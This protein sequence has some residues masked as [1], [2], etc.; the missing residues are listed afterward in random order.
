MQHVRNCGPQMF[1]YSRKG[2]TLLAINDF[3]Y[4][5]NLKRFG[6]NSDKVY[7]ECIHN[8]S[9][10]CRSRL[11]TIGDDLYVTN[12]DGQRIATARRAGLLIY[13]K[14]SSIGQNVGKLQCNT[15]S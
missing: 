11:K 4:R 14:F 2:G 8:R 13:K 1:I 10:K 7:W 5:S 3:I 15:I 12:G 9:K 6:R